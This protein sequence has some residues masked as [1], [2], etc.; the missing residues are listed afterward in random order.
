MI[1]DAVACGTA[2]AGVVDGDLFVLT[3]LNAGEIPLAPVTEA[4]GSTPDL[5]GALRV[6]TSLLALGDDTLPP[7]S[8]VGADSATAGTGSPSRL[9][10]GHI[11]AADSV[12]LE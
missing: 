8:A 1:V 6:P 9:P 12:P 7:M 11:V 5:I 4:S 10:E 2:S 3:V